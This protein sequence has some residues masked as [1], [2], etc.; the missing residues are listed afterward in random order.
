[1]TFGSDL[2]AYA[3]RLSRSQRSALVNLGLGALPWINRAFGRNHTSPSTW[4]TYITAREGLAAISPHVA[5]SMLGC[6]RRRVRPE[7]KT[8]QFLRLGNRPSLKKNTSVPDRSELRAPTGPKFKFN[9]HTMPSGPSKT[10]LALAS[11]DLWIR[12]E[13]EQFCTDSIL[14]PWSYRKSPNGT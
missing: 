10:R 14:S 8:A 9:R 13:R 1:M 7:R 11:Q 2:A 5:A 6:W 3:R 12:D 4:V